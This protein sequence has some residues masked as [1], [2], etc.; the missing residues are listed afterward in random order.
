MYH[1][2][3]CI[4]GKNTAAP[5]GQVDERSR[6]LAAQHGHNH[7]HLPADLGQGQDNLKVSMMLKLMIHFSVLL[8]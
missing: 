8:Y 3:R 6:M 4:A 7:S 1:R 5:D 2:R